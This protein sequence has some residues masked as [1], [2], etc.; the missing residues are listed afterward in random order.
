MKF[1]QLVLT[2]IIAIVCHQMSYFK[3]EMHQI[4][5]RLGLC[6]RASW[7]SLQ[8]SPRPFSWWGGGGWGLAAPSP[9]T[10]PLPRPRFPA[11]RVSDFG[12]FGASL[13]A[14]P[15]YHYSS[16]RPPTLGRLEYTLLR[17]RNIFTIRYTIRYAS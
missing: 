9:R 6:P 12:A 8:R 10:P 4:R 14:N 16:P 15:K 17:L 13:S 3:A 7:G 5:F 2:K 1:G 11:L